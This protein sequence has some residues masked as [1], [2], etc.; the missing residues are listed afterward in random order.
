MQNY[1][2]IETES[3]T[4]RAHSS[5]KEIKENLSEILFY[6]KTQIGYCS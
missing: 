6:P 4:I 1:V 2:K 5:L 3:E